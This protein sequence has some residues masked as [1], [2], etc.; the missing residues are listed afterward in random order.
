MPEITY[1]DADKEQLAS[2]EVKT[3]LQDTGLSFL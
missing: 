2:Y 3:E 1:Y